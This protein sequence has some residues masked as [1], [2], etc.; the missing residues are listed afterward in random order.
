[1]ARRQSTSKLTLSMNKLLA[2]LMVAPCWIQSNTKNSKRTLPRPVKIDFT[3]TGGTWTQALIAKQLDPVHNAFA[4]IGLK[5]TILT[6]SRPS[7]CTVG[8]RE[9][10][11][12][13]SYLTT[14]LFVRAL[15]LINRCV[16][17]S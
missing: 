7:K 16:V 15:F 4:A 17:G 9:P 13:A 6:I 3:C 12:H 10:G 2:M 5:N 8:R 14:S 11:V 1:M